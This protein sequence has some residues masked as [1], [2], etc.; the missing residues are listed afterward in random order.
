MIPTYRPELALL[1]QTLES[2]L[3]QDP[4]A[5]QMQIEVV[6]DCS[7]DANVGEMVKAIAGTRVKVT[8]TPK[9]LGLA[10]SWNVCIERARGQWVHILHHDDYVLPD[11][12]MR[13]RRVA[14]QHPEAALI[15]S[16]CFLVDDQ[17]IILGATPRVEALESG[18]RAVECFFYSNPIQC[19]GVAI[20]RKFYE[21]Q[22]GF[23][24]DLLFVLDVEMWARAVGLEGGVVISDVLA[25]YR[26]AQGQATSRLER[27]GDSLRDVERLIEI[28]AGRYPTFDPR[29]S[30]KQLCE[31]AFDQTRQ[32][33]KMGDVEAANASRYFWKTSTPLHM[34]LM[35]IAH[36]LLLTIAR[37]IASPRLDC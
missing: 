4:G 30:L 3:Q 2:V 21:V 28:Y 9:N 19:P 20:R 6:D 17:G 24:T 32:F 25:C 10:G 36:R 15:A 13:L 8:Q 31:K 29:R 27:S 26:T 12:Y 7:P 5:D 14:E 22:G 23:R 16:R 33:S 34:R 35:V 37:R 11:F 1:R 18:G